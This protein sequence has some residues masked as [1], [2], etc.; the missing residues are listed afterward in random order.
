MPD[1]NFDYDND[2][3]G[4]KGEPEWFKRVFYVKPLSEYD[5]EDGIT[6]AASPALTLQ[7]ASPVLNGHLPEPLRRYMGGLPFDDLT[8]GTKLPLYR[9]YEAGEFVRVR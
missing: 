7:L 6:P 3:D 2:D 9:R 8:P 5:D 4:D 1:T